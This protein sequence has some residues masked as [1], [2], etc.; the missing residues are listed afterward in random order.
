MTT[1]SSVSLNSSR[2]RKFPQN[3]ESLCDHE[4]D[5]RK[6][7]HITRVFLRTSSQIVNVDFAKPRA[8]SKERIQSDTPDAEIVSDQSDVPDAEIVSDQSDTPDANTYSG[9]STHQRSAVR[10]S[11]QPRSSTTRY[12]T[13]SVITSLPSSTPYLVPNEPGVG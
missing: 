10:Q 11:V 7:R 3:E 12:G 5:D 2:E 9:R 1:A 13:S 6:T 8:A 4:L